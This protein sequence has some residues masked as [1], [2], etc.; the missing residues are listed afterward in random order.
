[1]MTVNKAGNSSSS[2]TKKKKTSSSS[3]TAS[4]STSKTSKVVDTKASKHDIVHSAGLS[5][6]SSSSSLHIS[7]VSHLPLQAHLTTYLVTETLPTGSGEKITTYHPDTGAT[8]TE[9]RHFV[10]QDTSSQHSTDIQQIGS[11]LN[12][13]IQNLNES[14]SNLS[15]VSGSTYTVT[16]PMEELRLSYN[17]NDSAWNGKFI[18]E[19]TVQK[20]KRNSIVKQ[21]STATSHEEKSSSAKT[22]SSSY[23]VEIV[24]GKER[25]I[26]QK[27]HE[28]SH[29][30]NSSNDERLDMKSGTGIEPEVHYKQKSTKS[31][32]KMD[33]AK[34]ELQQP[35]TR[36][37]QAV[38]EIHQVGDN[39]TSSTNVIQDKNVSSTHALRDKTIN[40]IDNEITDSISKQKSSTTSTKNLGGSSN[41]TRTVTYY[42]EK[43]NVVKTVTEVDSSATPVS[44]VTSS[45]ATKTFSDQK[46]SNISTSRTTTDSKN[47]HGH[48]VDSSST[49][50]DSTGRVVK[51]N[52]IHSTT[53]I[54]TNDRL[55]G[56]SQKS[57]PVTSTPRKPSSP[58]GKHPSKEKS[59]TKTDETTTYYVDENYCDTNKIRQ[60]QVSSDSSDFY[61]HRVDSTKTVVDN[62]YDTSAIQNTIGYR[63]NVVM[64]QNMDT[65]DL[66]FSNDRNYGKTGWNGQFTYET[67]QG[68]KKSTSPDRKSPPTEKPDKPASRRSQSPT[69]NPIKKFPDQLPAAGAPSR[70]SPE[71]KGANQLHKLKTS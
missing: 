71:N 21:S 28:A 59:P 26:D 45:D 3:T 17:P 24:D 47:F 65:T 56:K 54:H 46:T 43:G 34:P 58:E 50:H 10:A 63:E 41:A 68:S 2:T 18:Q 25:I 44:E 14:T 69:K 19:Q 5:K 35:K 15:Q 53:D 67:P 29:A 11:I 23:A 9:Y 64:D 55:H 49:I 39:I 66:V 33:S 20:G 8:S 62:V 57:S 38:K 70:K 36:S 4:T 31:S 60:S 16:E 13:S 52:T 48:V 30:T 37:S 6:S 40:F 32:T 42:D 12:Q 27:H 7:D 61:G 51:D 22:T 1:M